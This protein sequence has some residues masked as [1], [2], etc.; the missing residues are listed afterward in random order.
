MSLLSS[1][2]FSSQQLN[3]HP[4][5]R[6]L[7]YPNMPMINS[8][9]FQSA[10]SMNTITRPSPRRS[11]GDYPSGQ[12]VVVTNLV[13]FWLK[14]NLFRP[15]FMIWSSMTS[16]WPRSSRLLGWTTT[17]GCKLFSTM[18]SWRGS[19]TNTIAYLKNFTRLPRNLWHKKPEKTS[20][21][22]SNSR[23]Y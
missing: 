12:Q 7:L 10:S 20:N 21:Q 1:N 18:K 23:L 3:N 5:N 17:S 8:R 15:R 19:V 22:Y 6:L 13:F 9:T 11:G 4:T 14:T 2:H 16:P